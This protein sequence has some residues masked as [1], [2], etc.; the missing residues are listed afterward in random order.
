MILSLA[1]KNIW[2]NKKR[3]LIITIAISFGLWGGLF[4]GAVMMGMMESIVE[5]AINRDL[6]HI[7]VHKADYSKEKEI[8]NYIPGGIHV[9][10]NISKID[11]V[12]VA[13]GR[14]LIDGMI[15]SPTSSFGTKIVGINPE[16]AIKVTDINQSLL[17]GTYFN[18]KDRNQIIVGKKLSERFG[19]A[20]TTTSNLPSLEFT[21]LLTSPW[22]I[23][24]SF[25][26]D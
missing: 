19:R 8:I 17:E 22:I 6:S 11:M 3:S 24:I 21:F 18:A 25:T 23:S 14:T 2:R 26:K 7:Q 5:T 1:W 16:D 9:L 12:K 13:S 10:E 4:S 20:I 15:S